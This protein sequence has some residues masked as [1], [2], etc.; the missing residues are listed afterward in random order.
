MSNDSKDELTLRIGEKLTAARIE[1]GYTQTRAA[2]AVGTSQSCKKQNVNIII[3]LIKLYGA[4]YED[5]FGLVKVREKNSALGCLDEGSELLRELIKDSGIKGLETQTDMAV[6]IC[7]YMLLRKLYS[8]NPH[9][10]HKLFELDTEETMERCVKYLSAQ[11]KDLD[12]IL[13]MAG[14]KVN[15]LEVSVGKNPELRAFIKE[16]E[17]ILLACT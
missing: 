10:S 13:G 2:R 8:E 1:S 15:R 17:H 9:N 12:R 3:A 16:C 5:V 7:T 6:K 4:S 11:P 14:K